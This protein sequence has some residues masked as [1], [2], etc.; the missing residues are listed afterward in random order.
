M[1]KKNKKGRREGTARGNAR[2]QVREPAPAS[3]PEGVLVEF[4]GMEW[5]PAHT[6][7]T[8]LSPVPTS[9]CDDLD[10]GKSQ[11]LQSSLVPPSSNSALSP[12]VQLI[13]KS[14]SSLMA[15]HSL[16]LCQHRP[17]PQPRLHW[18]PSAFQLHLCGYN[19]QLGSVLGFQLASSA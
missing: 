2:G 8:E 3:I 9:W 14:P 16:P 19:L 5:N 1:V 7:T 11:N 10:N 17:V 6:P 15:P 4:E 12:L 13:S 18:L